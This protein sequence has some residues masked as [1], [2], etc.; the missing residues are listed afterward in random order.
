VRS[1]EL[2]T[3]SATVA[4]ARFVGKWDEEG[5][6]D[7]RNARRLVKS[8]NTETPDLRGL[9]SAAEW[10]RTITSREGHKALTRGIEGVFS[11]IQR[12]QVT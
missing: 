1:V 4:R 6:R 2:N 10:S 11:S 5:T 8:Y 7:W 3:L 12:S 9:P